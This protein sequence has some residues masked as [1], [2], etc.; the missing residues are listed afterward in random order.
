MNV[1]LEFSNNIIY[2][3]ATRP[4]FNLSSDAMTDASTLLLEKNL[5]FVPGGNPMFVLNDNQVNFAN[6]K[7]GYKALTGHDDSSLAVADPLYAITS[8]TSTAPLT[9]QATSPVMGVAGK[10][11][12]GVVPAD[13]LGVSRPLNGKMEIGAYEY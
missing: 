8:G 7:T 12:S 2:G 5:F 6:W 9:L 3:S 11:V 4:V 1:G 10:D 13:R